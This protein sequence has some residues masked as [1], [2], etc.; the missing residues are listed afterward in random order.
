MQYKSVI[1]FGRARIIEDKGMKLKV[2]REMIRKYDP[3]KHVENIDLGLLNG[4]SIYEIE[5]NEITGRK[6][7]Y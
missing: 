3:D 1:I 6:K 7:H 4:L 5:I 2:L